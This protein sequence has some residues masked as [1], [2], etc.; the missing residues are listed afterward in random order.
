MNKH[1]F[2]SILLL[3]VFAA[4]LAL[5]VLHI[6]FLAV[7]VQQFLCLLTP[8]F[9]GL[10]IAFLLHKP[11]DF[12]THRYQALFHGRGIKTAR[13]LAVLTAYAILFLTIYALLSILIPQVILSFQTFAGNLSQTDG[14]QDSVNWLADRYH[15]GFLKELDL[16][17][18]DTFL[19]TMLENALNKLQSS[20][21]DT[22]PRL[23]GAVTS[24]IHGTVTLML[25]LAFSVYMLVGTEKLTR[26]FH[27][28]T[29]FYL[30]AQLSRP[31]LRITRLTIDTFSH[32]VN[33]QITE[34]G[35]LGGLCF[36]GMKLFS[37]DYAPL[38]SVI[39]GITALV[40]VIGAYF[41]GFVSAFLLLMI[42]P[43]QALGFLAFLFILQQIENNLIY[44]RVVGTS[45]GL[46]GIWVLMAVTVGS[47]L[48]GVAGVFLSVPA[49]AVLYT[50]LGND[51]HRREQKDSSRFP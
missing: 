41:G 2:Q 48:F 22:L 1:T 4:F 46:P 44:P 31:V 35:I 34:A 19:H 29:V 18:L 15:L 38:I 39:I 27:R 45:I 13:G 47:G 17:N 40:P 23:F 14:L 12:F 33:G 20:I 7:C 6:G 36:V 21:A 28:L 51:L 26:Q 5:L 25:G 24:F 10:A 8:V 30:P 42:N 50:L 11:C 3:L 16:S 32:F 43:F 9:L 49:A 37:F